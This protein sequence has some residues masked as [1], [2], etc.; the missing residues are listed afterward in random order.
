ADASAPP[1]R[2]NGPLVVGGDV[3]QFALGSQRAAHLAGQD[4]DE[5]FELYGAP[6]AGG[7]ALKLSGT[8]VVG[9]D[10]TEFLLTPDGAS[11]VFLADALV[12]GQPEFFRVPLDGSSAPIALD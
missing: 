11:A 7:A 4:A 2:L 9:G 5:V 6:I 8:L 12:D 3:T 1:V 10:V